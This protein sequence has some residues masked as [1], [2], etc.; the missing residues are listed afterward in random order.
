MQIG[1]KIAQIRK[2]KKIQQQVL[3]D[4]LGISNK[5]LSE[6][7]NGKKYP[8]WEMLVKILNQLEAKIIIQNSK[9]ITEETEIK[10]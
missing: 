10:F 3:A 1:E 8:R 4:L 6:I 5:H 9:T 2:D 7:E